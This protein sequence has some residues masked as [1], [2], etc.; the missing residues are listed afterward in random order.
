M[1]LTITDPG[2]IALRKGIRAA[3]AL[4]LAIAIALYAVNDVSGMLFT[5]F[6]TVGLLINADF[7]GSTRQRTASYLLTGVAGSVALAVGWAASFVTAIAVVVTV[8]VAF[9]LS[10]ANLLRGTIALGTPAVLLVFVVAVSIDGTSTDLPDYQLGWW[11]AV[12]VSTVSALLLF[13]HNRR[14]DQRA[15]LASAFT[16]AARCAE[17]TWVSPAPAE[18]RDSPTTPLPSTASTP[19]T[20]APPTGQT[21]SRAVTRR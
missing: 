8:V 13:P 3:V 19:S 2:H 16:A 17:R 18:P 11:I 7:A 14:A 20:E 1:A 21:A 15:A 12:A 6:G 5:V 9:A 4:P 10:F